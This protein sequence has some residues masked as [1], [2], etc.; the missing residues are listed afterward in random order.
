MSEQYIAPNTTTAEWIAIPFQVDGVNFSCNI[1]GHGRVVVF[2]EGV[3]FGIW[4]S[5]IEKGYHS[6][7]YTHKEE[8]DLELK[9]N[10]ELYRKTLAKVKNLL[11]LL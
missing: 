4:D 1:L 6:A 3:H 10:L 2:R 11:A 5:E 7:I 9:N 8:G